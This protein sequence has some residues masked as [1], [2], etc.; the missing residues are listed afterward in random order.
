MCRVLV[1]PVP[2]TFPATYQLVAVSPVACTG[3]ASKMTTDG[4]KVKLPSNP[5]SSSAESI[6]KVRTGRVKLLI[7][8]GMV[9]IGKATMIG[10][11]V[12]IGNGFGEARV[13]VV[14]V[15]PEGRVTVPLLG[16]EAPA[17]TALMLC[18]N[19]CKSRTVSPLG[20]GFSNFNRI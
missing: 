11:G 13:T 2:I 17:V 1:E 8:V 6:V 20:F 18:F 3:F 5:I 19:A 16:L 9:D 15:V 14:V 4:S 10:S 7:D 12:G